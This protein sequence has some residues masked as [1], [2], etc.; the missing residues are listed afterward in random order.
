MGKKANIIT[1]RK[2][3]LNEIVPSQKFLIKNNFIKTLKRCFDKKGTIVTYYSTSAAGNTAI[4]NVDAFYTTAKVNLLKKKNFSKKLKNKKNLKNSKKSISIS[5]KNI[6]QK[7][8]LL[9]KLAKL[10]K[11]SKNKSYTKRAFFTRKTK[12]AN[13]RKSKKKK[14][15]KTIILRKAKYAKKKSIK[16][17]SDFNKLFKDFFNPQTQVLLGVNIINKQENRD[18]KTEFNIKLK[19]FKGALFSRRSNLYYDCIKLCSLFATKKITTEVF[20][21]TLGTIFKF[22]QKKSH[23]KFLAFVKIIINTLITPSNFSD[24]NIYTK[25]SGIKMRMN[26]KLKGKLRASSFSCSAGKI[27]QQTIKANADYSLTHIKTVYGCFGLKIWVNYKPEVFLNSSKKRRRSRIRKFLLKKY[28]LGLKNANVKFKRFKKIL[29]KNP[30][31]PI[32]NK[33]ILKNNIDNKN[34]TKTSSSNISIIEE[35]PSLPCDKNTYIQKT[36]KI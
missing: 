12:Q 7:E 29:V 1:L 22:L 8:T 23:G 19:R 33:Y 21:N 11:L 9:K 30:I 24:T 35:L 14:I 5:K 18:L 28:K 13:K 4:I 32:K 36:K 3:K 20:C 6:S 25:I 26:G 16:A 31:K 27:S 15:S 17:Y 10:K 34:F 2:Q